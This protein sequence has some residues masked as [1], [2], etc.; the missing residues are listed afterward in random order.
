MNVKLLTHGSFIITIDDKEVKGRFDMMAIEN[1]CNLH[2]IPGILALTENFQNGM[3]PSLYADF[4]LCGIHRTYAT[5]EHCELKKDVI[6]KAI[7]IMGG[8]S[9]NDF[10]KLMAHGMKLFV[11]VTNN[12]HMLE[13]DDEEK[14]ILGLPTAGSSSDTVQ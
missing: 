14:K 11:R 7:E 13:L 10:L 9:S 4:I 2:N 1:F 8:F 12:A 5:P 6:L 3:M